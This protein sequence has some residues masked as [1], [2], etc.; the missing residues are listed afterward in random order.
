MGRPVR[1]C[2][3]GRP[4]VRRATIRSR[5]SRVSSSRG[6]IRS[7]SSLPSGTF[8]QAPWPAISCT[9]SSSRS[10]SS[11]MRSP[12]AR[13]SS[14]ASACSRASGLGPDADRCSSATASRRSASGGQVAGQRVRGV[15]DVAGEHQRP[16]RGVG[17]APLGDVG[18][19]L[20]DGEDLPAPVPDRVRPPVRM[21][22]GGQRGQPGFD[23]RAPVQRGQVGDRRVAGGSGTGRTRPGGWRSP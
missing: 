10:S 16:G 7:V 12:V 20:A 4:G 6:T 5:T 21:P 19:E 14:S 17:P 22:G 1:G 11:P 23:V 15:G 3:S 18:E 2:G 8:S 9:Q 13:V